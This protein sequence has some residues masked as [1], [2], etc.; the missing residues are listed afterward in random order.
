MGNFSLCVLH[1]TD[2]FFVALLF[3]AFLSNLRFWQDG[4]CLTVFKDFLTVQ[5]CLIELC[6]K[7]SSYLL[8]SVLK[9]SFTKCG[10]EF[11]YKNVVLQ[12]E[13]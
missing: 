13:L 12:S 8:T 3:I 9:Y 2:F 10:L 6:S 1:V 7:L 4:I 5:T 11:G